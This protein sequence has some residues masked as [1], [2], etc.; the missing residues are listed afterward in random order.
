MRRP[1]GTA[2]YSL[3]SSQLEGEVTAE[4]EYNIK[5]LAAT[6]YAGQ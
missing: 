5:W 2:R 6:L 1:A 3:T 4:E